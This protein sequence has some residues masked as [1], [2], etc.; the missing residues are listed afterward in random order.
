MPIVNH[1]FTTDGARGAAF[2]VVL[3]LYLMMGMYVHTR[4]MLA[5]CQ[6]GP[7]RRRLGRQEGQNIHCTGANQVTVVDVFWALSRTADRMSVIVESRVMIVQLP[8]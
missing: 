3:D 8:T 6:F 1:N 4:R 7:G 2:A 5:R